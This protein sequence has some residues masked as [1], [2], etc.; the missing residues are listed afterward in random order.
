MKITFMEQQHGV[1]Y[2]KKNDRLKI[3]MLR[4]LITPGI[5]AYATLLDDM[6]RD[7][8]VTETKMGKNDFLTV[9]NNT[10]GGRKYS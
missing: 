4:H 9:L 3:F 7:R 5:H 10:A 2:K 8:Q 1:V 6:E